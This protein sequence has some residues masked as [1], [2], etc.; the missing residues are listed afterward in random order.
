MASRAPLDDINTWLL[1]PGSFD[2]RSNSQLNNARCK[3]L[4]AFQHHRPDW[5]ATFST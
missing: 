2:G 3:R 5:K 1:L 4:H